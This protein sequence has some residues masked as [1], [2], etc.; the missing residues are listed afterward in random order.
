M[1]CSSHLMFMVPDSKYST[2]NNGILYSGKAV[3][4]IAGV[5]IFTII[6]TSYGIG[7]KNGSKKY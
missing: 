6:D 4:G 2:A 5:F 1:D 3:A 7:N